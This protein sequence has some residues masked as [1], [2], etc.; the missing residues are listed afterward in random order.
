M[1]GAWGAGLATFAGDR[2]LEVFYPDPRLGEHDGAFT[3]LSAEQ[4]EQHG[5][6]GAQRTDDR[7]GVREAAVLT[8][9]E[10]L[11]APPDGAAD[12]YLRLH[13]LSHRLVKPRGLNMDGIF[14][15]LPNVAWTSAGPVDP[16]KLT[17]VQFAPAPPG[18]RCRSSRSTSSR[19]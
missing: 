6:P 11:Q 17:Q 18:R 19:A 13:L 8:V 15:A 16:A 12:A 1:S 7:R 2:I 4:A 5:L 10:D 9:I 14:A 3:E